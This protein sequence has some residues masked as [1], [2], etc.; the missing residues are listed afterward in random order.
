MT[1][2]RLLGKSGVGYK[3]CYTLQKRGFIEIDDELKA[4]E[5]RFG[6]GM[7]SEGYYI[8]DIWEQ[9]DI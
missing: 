8:H 3:A 9:M 1:V 4:S 2:F 6:L 7:I 5:Q